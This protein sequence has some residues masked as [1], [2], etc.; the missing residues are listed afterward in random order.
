MT[1]NHDYS[2]PTRGAQNWDEPINANFAQLDTD[3]EIRDT[4]ANLR[5]YTPE[6]G[7][8]FLATDTGVMY[9]GVDVGESETDIQ[10]VRQGV[11][12]NGEGFANE[13]RSEFAVVVGG[14]D[15]RAS[16]PR[17]AVLG[18]KSNLASG[19]G[20]V[21]AGK[22]ARA[23]HDGT[24]VFG[25][26]TATPVSSDGPGELRSQMPVY[27]PAFHTTSAR[28]KKTDIETV[29]PQDALDGVEALSIRSWRLDSDAGRHVG[30]MAGDFH[31]QFDLAGEETIATVD[32]DGVALAAIQALAAQLDRKD[33]RIDD[34]ERETERL[35]ERDARKDEQIAALEARL[36]AVEDRL[37]EHDTDSDA[38]EG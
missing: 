4:T 11:L 24:V 12:P 31:E 25:D 21:A 35:R 1:E 37:D 15:N 34:L 29:D 18:G 23:V 13:S 32:A 5:D 33:E 7:A 27:A 20:A 6:E 17:A 19:S 9:A 2:T 3:V 10:W 38:S 28:A 16:G 26:H 22:R 36:A 8:K 30:P 14:L